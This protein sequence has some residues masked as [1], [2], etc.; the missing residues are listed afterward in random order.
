MY[1]DKQEFMV[2]HNSSAYYAQCFQAPII[3]IIV[4]A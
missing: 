4:P 1:F 2:M 3:L